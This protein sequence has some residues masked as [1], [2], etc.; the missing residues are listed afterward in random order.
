MTV[1]IFLKTAL[2]KGR[3]GSDRDREL[4]RPVVELHG[5]AEHRDGGLDVTPSA[6]FDD[7]GRS[8]EP[9]FSRIFLPMSKVDHYIPL[10]E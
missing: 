3:Y 10:D 1:Q 6:L 7:K 5:T 8:V 4:S 2:Y 9:P